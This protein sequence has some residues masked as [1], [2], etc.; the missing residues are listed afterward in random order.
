M[1]EEKLTV[2]AVIKGL[3]DE[4]MDIFLDWLHY[5]IVYEPDK[6]IEDEKLREHIDIMSKFAKMFKELTIDQSLA[7]SRLVETTNGIKARVLEEVFENVSAGI[8]EGRERYA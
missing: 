2:G 6:A 8:K 7:I 3:T 1:D 4:Q 5:Y